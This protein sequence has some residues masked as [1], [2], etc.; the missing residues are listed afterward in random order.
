MERVL[1]AFGIELR[2]CLIEKQRHRTDILGDNGREREPQGEIDLV[3]RRTGK[4]RF[5]SQPVSYTHLDVYKRQG[6]RYGERAGL[7]H[8]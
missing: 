7:S 1:Q 3:D 6:K 8:R 5:F 4:R 2:Q